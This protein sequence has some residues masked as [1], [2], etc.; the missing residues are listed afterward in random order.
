M[1]TTKELVRSEAMNPGQLLAQAIDKGLTVESLEKL[2]AL[3][4]RW[5]ANQ[6]RK[7]FF[8]SLSEFQRACPVLKKTK[9]V[10]FK[11][12]KYKY[13]P[14]ASIVNQV[15]DILSKNGL[16]YRWET[17]DENLNLTVT[18]II[19]HKDGHFESTSMSATADDSG[20]KNKI[21]A[22]GSAITYLQRY[23]LIGALGISSADDDNDGRTS[24]K[25][26]DQLHKEYMAILNPMIQKDSAA[27]S[28]YLPDNWK[29]EQTIENYVKAIAAL[30]LKTK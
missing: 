15:K 22:R 26:L 27:W 11:D 13:V 30:K 12:V 18:C 28:K 17:K 4:E 20:S 14:L 2:M 19:T 8:E 1:E 5:E 3:Q 7:Y 10:A 16:T 29:D 9:T 25:S 24:E 23:T 6:A 21:Q